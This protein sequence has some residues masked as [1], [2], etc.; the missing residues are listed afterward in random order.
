MISSWVDKAAQEF[1]NRRGYDATYLYAQINTRSRKLCKK[2]DT[3]EL[4]LHILVNWKLSKVE[5]ISHPHRSLSYQKYISV[6]VSKIEKASLNISILIRSLCQ[7]ALHW[8]HYFLYI[9]NIYIF[10]IHLL[11]ITVYMIISTI[12]IYIYTIYNCKPFI[13]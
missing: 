1:A 3:F 6:K 8:P 11:Y 13:D 2:V 12:Y 5:H 4:Y 9:Y 7:C 10:R